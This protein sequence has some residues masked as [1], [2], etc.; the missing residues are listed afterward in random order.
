M[1]GTAPYEQLQQCQHDPILWN[2]TAIAYT[3]GVAIAS[4][5]LTQP[6]L[7]VRGSVQGQH[8]QRYAAMAADQAASSGATLC[9]L[10]MPCLLHMQ[11]PLLQA[12]CCLQ[13]RQGSVTCHCMLTIGCSSACRASAKLSNLQV[14]SLQ[15]PCILH[16][17]GT[18]LIQGCS[19]QSRAQG[20]LPYLCFHNPA[21]G[22]PATVCVHAARKHQHVTL[23]PGAMLV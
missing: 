19:L 2:K 23:P 11:M 16:T 8:C 18:L 9:L 5:A 10:W 6:V 15:G 12:C 20:V 17:R 1:S 22:Q 3:E 21:G 4:S 13:C 7:D 14:Q